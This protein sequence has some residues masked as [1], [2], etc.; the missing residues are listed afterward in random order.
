[1]E[2]LIVG[3]VAQEPSKRLHLY[4]MHGGMYGSGKNGKSEKDL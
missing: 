1:M 2:P 3:F 4:Y